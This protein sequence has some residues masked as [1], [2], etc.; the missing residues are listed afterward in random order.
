MKSLIA[1][2]PIDMPQREPSEGCNI[3]LLD[4]QLFGEVPLESHQ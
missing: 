1:R 4:Q 3:R 2:G